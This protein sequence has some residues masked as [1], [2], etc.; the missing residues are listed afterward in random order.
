MSSVLPQHL[1]K[2][3]GSIRDFDAEKIVLAVAKAGRATNEFDEKEARRVVE[4][5][6]LPR[7]SDHDASRTPNIEWVQDAV[8]HALFETARRTCTC[9]TSTCFRATAPAGRSERC[10]KKA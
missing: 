9:T 5:H 2:R 4:E 8:E 3:D 6:V 10:C 7:L 1:L